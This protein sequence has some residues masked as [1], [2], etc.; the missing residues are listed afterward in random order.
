MR[1]SEQYGFTWNN[2]A[3][4][5][6]IITISRSKNGQARYI[7][8][9][10]AAFAALRTAHEMSNGKP[11]VFLNRYG[12]QLMRPRKWFEAAIKQVGIQDFSWHCVRHT[13]QA[14]L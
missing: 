13:S 3:F 4:E 6:R 11:W 1:L 10:D 5:R 7:P 14:A 12:E 8:L 9:N 2:V